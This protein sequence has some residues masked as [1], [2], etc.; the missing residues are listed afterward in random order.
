VKY[1]TNP[2]W[3][4]LPEGRGRWRAKCAKRSQFPARRALGNSQLCET[5]P[6]LPAARVSDAANARNEPNFRLRRGGR[7]LGPGVAGQS[8]ETKPI[9]NNS[10]ESLSRACRRNAQATK[11]RLC[12]TKPNSGELGH[13]GNGIRDGGRGENLCHTWADLVSFNGK[14]LQLS[15]FVTGI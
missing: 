15:C 6:I 2:I 3:A 13:L 14:T 4:E 7:G 5:K 11:R 1:E 8:C 10:G 12:E 9:R